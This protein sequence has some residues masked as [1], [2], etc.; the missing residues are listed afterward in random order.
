VQ[1]AKRIEFN[2]VPIDDI[3]S[4]DNLCQINLDEEDTSNNEDEEESSSSKLTS[5]PSR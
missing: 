5:M 4:G 1:I 3:D 2:E